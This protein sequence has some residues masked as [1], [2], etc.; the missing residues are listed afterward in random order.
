M[1]S[2]VRKHGNTYVAVFGPDEDNI[3]SLGKFEFD[4]DAESRQRAK[5]L[6]QACLKGGD[7][8]R[9]I[10]EA[11]IRQLRG[12]GPSYPRAEDRR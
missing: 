2:E 4:D 9:K 10:F 11:M 3:V 5:G 12:P 1:I 6:A 8:V 7:E